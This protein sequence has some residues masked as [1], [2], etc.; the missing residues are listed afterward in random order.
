MKVLIE[1]AG[2]EILGIHTDADEPVE[3][4]V[5][6]HD[7]DEPHL[8]YHQ[9]EPCADVEERAECIIGEAYESRFAGT[10]FDAN[11]APEAGR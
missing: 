3:L 9:A 8:G 4:L 2:G 5:L 10:M 6:D 7:F 1:V 11:N